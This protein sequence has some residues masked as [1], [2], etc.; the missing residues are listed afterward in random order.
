MWHAHAVNKSLVFSHMHGII[1]NSPINKPQ[2]Y[3]V[4]LLVLGMSYGNKFLWSKALLNL[5][6]LCRPQ[7]HKLSKNGFYWS[8]RH[9]LEIK[10]NW[11][12]QKIN[13]Y[14]G[15][16][17]I[18]YT[19][20]N[21]MNWKILLYTGLFTPYIIFALLHV[22]TVLPCL[23]FIQTEGK[24]K[25]GANIPLNTVTLLEHIQSM[26]Y[27]LT[28]G[29]SLTGTYSFSEIVWTGPMGSGRSNGILPLPLWWNNC[30]RTLL[31]SERNKKY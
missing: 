8:Y 1:K 12:S 18:M 29:C 7:K 28:S 26:F 25:T 22:Q 10:Q 21:Y 24:N 9:Q 14:I 11:K 16:K 3:K 13:T 19:I 23:Q 5:V 27:V 6:L 17:T 15:I 2:N 20:R 30:K 4:T 31:I